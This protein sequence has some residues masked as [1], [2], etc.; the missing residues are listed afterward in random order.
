MERRLRRLTPRYARDVDA[1]DDLLQLTGN[2]AGNGGHSS[3]AAAQSTAGFSRHAATSVTTTFG[4]RLA[5]VSSPS[6][7]TL[8]LR[9]RLRTDACVG[10]DALEF[11][12][13]VRRENIRT[14]NLTASG[15]HRPGSGVDIALRRERRR[16]FVGRRCTRTRPAR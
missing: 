8:P 13:K 14:L 16:V 5:G 11:A 6:R 15:E 4:V 10:G 7:R 3:T 1:V 12:H 2:G 9:W